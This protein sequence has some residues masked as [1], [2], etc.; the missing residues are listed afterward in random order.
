MD[1]APR[2]TS[3]VYQRLEAIAEEPS[4]VAT[5]SDVAANARRRGYQSLPPRTLPLSSS[6]RPEGELSLSADTLQSLSEALA[7]DP[8]P[9]KE[10]CSVL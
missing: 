1:P 4:Y 10:K 5:A 3:E 8:N 7:D 9:K 2:T 6:P